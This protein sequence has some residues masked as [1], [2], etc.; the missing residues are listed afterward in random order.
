MNTTRKH[1]AVF[2]A[3]LIFLPSVFQAAD[4]QLSIPGVA[5]SIL[6]GDGYRFFSFTAD[7]SVPLL[8]TATLDKDATKILD[9]PASN[10][11]VLTIKLGKGNI[12]QAIHAYYAGGSAARTYGKGYHE[13][14]FSTVYSSNPIEIGEPFLTLRSPE[15][16]LVFTLSKQ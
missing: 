11:M 1:L 6:E 10:E 4:S 7:E 13:L 14:N 5:Q 3:A 16:Y 2:L 9:I 12:V 15:H 8:L